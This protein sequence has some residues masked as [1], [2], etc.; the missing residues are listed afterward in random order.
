MS[1]L[2]TRSAVFA[3]DWKA[4]L[5]AAQRFMPHLCLEAIE[6]PPHGLFDA[7]LAR[8][9]AVHM[10]VRRLMWPVRRVALETHRPKSNV[11]H[12]AKTVDSRMALPAFVRAYERALHGSP[13]GKER[14]AHG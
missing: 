6:F 7:L 13:T 5:E 10:M 2:V 14:R 1:A 9:V 8:Q 12:A 11:M 3:H 4:C